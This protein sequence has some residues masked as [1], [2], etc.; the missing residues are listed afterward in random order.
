MMSGTLIP[1]TREMKVRRIAIRGLCGQ[2]LVT[3][4][5]NKK[6]GHGGTVHTVIQLYVRGTG[7][8]I[9]VGGSQAKM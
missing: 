2:M 9:K 6:P 4:L 3:S 5:L 1:A 7:R 8:R